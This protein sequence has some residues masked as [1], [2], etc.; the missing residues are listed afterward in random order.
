VRQ[1][2]DGLNGFILNLQKEPT[3]T[4]IIGDLQKVLSRKNW[5]EI[6]FCGFGEPLERLDVVLEVTEWIKRNHQIPVR[7]NTNGQG[8]LLNKGRDV[9]TELKAAGV[10]KVNVSLNAPDKQTYIKI[11]NPAFDNAYEAVLEFIKKAKNVMETEAT[12]VH[13]PDLDMTKVK[14]QAKAMGVKFRVR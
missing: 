2:K 1:F 10:D 13:L 12:A 7:V 11:C 6:V 4:E 9:V 3:A 5:G 14:E 8:C